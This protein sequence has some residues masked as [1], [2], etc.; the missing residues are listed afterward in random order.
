MSKLFSSRGSH[1]A[2]RAGLGLL[3]IMTMLVSMFGTAFAAPATAPVAAPAADQ[4]A[5]PARTVSNPP[6]NER[7]PWVNDTVHYDNLSGTIVDNVFSIVPPCVG[8]VTNITWWLHK[9]KCSSVAE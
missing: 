1:T 6:D 8:G 2:V 5:S 4:Q 9:W 3:V 7:S